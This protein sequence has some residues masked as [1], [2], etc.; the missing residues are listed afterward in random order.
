MYGTW[1]RFK[2]H[3]ESGVNNPNV[4][5]QEFKTLNKASIKLDI[6]LKSFA[7][8]AKCVINQQLSMKR[9]CAVLEFP[10][11]TKLSFRFEYVSTRQRSLSVKF[12]S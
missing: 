10:I 6:Q 5:L 11:T 9:N 12:L 1:I 7:N 2:I 8:C 4:L 3:F